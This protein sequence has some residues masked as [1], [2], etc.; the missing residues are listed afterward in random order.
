VNESTT[1]GQSSRRSAWSTTL[2]GTGCRSRQTSRKPCDTPASSRMSGP[3]R[4]HRARSP[5]QSVPPHSAGGGRR[6]QT[7]LPREREQGDRVLCV[8]RQEA[9]P[10]SQGG[11]GPHRQPASGGALAGSHLA[12]AARRG[13]GGGHRHRDRVRPRSALGAARSVPQS[14][15]IRWGRRHHPPAAAPGPKSWR[16]GGSCLRRLRPSAIQQAA[17]TRGVTESALGGW[18]SGR[19]SP[20]ARARQFASKPLHE[21]NIWLH[22]ATWQANGAA[23]VPSRSTS[24]VIPPPS[25]HPPSPRCTDPFTMQSDHQ[26]EVAN[27]WFQTTL[28]ATF[29]PTRSSPAA[30]CSRRMSRG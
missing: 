29:I 8:D 25:G 18:L 24:K 6:R 22:K 16:A 15:C 12:G 1:A 13:F 3:E 2:R 19:L 27:H 20:G 26:R 11:Q 10:H 23:F 7:D 17:S 28:C 4:T 30:C 9:D 14:A 21:R 5:V